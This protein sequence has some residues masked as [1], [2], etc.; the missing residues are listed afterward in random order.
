[1]L[2][3]LKRDCRQNLL[4]LLPVALIRDEHR[5]FVPDVPEAL[6]VVRDRLGEDQLIRHMHDAAGALIGID[7]DADFVHGKLEQMDV[8]D[9]AAMLGDFDAVADVKGAAPHDERPGGEVRE[10]VLQRNRHARRHQ[11][12]ECGE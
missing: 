2:G 1:M 10:R 3:V 11:T 6:V 8:D 7:P 4:R 12:E 5:H 9:I